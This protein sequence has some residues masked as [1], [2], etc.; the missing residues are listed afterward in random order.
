MGR[1]VFEEGKDGMGLL[2]RRGEGEHAE[3]GGQGAGYGACRDGMVWEFR[4]LGQPE[5]S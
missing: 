4:C 3:A 2:V 5:V 1:R